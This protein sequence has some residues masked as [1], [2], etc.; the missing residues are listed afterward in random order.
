VDDLQAT[1]GFK[2]VECPVAV[3]QLMAA[4]DAER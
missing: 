3:E 1:V 4:A 2:R